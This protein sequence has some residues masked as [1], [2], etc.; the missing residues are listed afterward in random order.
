MEKTRPHLSHHL[1]DNS[2]PSF[3]FGSTPPKEGTEAAAASLSCKKF[4]AR[5]AVLATDGFIVYD[6]QDEA[7]RTNIPRVFPF[8]RTLDPSTYGK[9][10]PIHSGKECVIY[11]C[12]VNDTAENFTSW[13]DQATTNGHNSFV[14][15]GGASSKNA[16][17]LS[18]KD[19]AEI[20]NSNPLTEFGSVAIAERHIKKNNEHLNM[21]RKQNYG[22]KF[23]ITQG[24]F[25]PAPIIKLISDY[26]ELCKQ[27]DVTPKKVIL[28][29]APCG[30]EKTM[31]FIKWLGMTVP[32]EV[33]ERIFSKKGTG[34]KEGERDLGPV[35]ESC[36]ILA[37]VLR[38]VLDGIRG[39]NV[40][41][42]I[43]VE[44]LSIF[45]EEIDAAHTLFSKLQEMVLNDAGQPW[46]IRWYVIPKTVGDGGVAQRKRGYSEEEPHWSVY[47][48]VVVLDRKNDEYNK[49][50]WNLAAGVGG[51]VLGLGLSRVEWA[52]FH[53]IQKR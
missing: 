10:F 18:M 53:E 8:R 45:R 38:E 36:A 20:V 6:I 5:S 34:L 51:I 47:D 33:E 4:A 24:I 35:K 2:K 49:W 41:L 37:E 32:A 11:K 17:N 25:D 7:G 40:T 1:L 12:V 39:T 21:M 16:V 3:L 26:G 19:A 22:A 23:F 52:K 48:D 31:Q 9:N 43:N 14:L 44:S 28:T 30:R 50:W 13:L 46:A 29:F 42:G 15:V 27:L